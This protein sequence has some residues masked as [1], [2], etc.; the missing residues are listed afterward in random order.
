MFLY[1][2]GSMIIV[3]LS[4][5]LLFL[6]ILLMKPLRRCSVRINRWHNQLSRYMMWG[7]PITVFYESYTMALI[8]ALINLMNPLFD[9]KGDIAST[10]LSII[11]V[12]LCIFVPILFVVIMLRKFTYLRRHMI[13]VRWGA[14][15]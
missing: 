9:S 3:I 1:N 4:I 6:V 8:C 10:V 2:I 12:F 14:I 13:K 15:F 7:H 5:P 11:T